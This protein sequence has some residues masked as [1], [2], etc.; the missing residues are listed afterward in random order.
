MLQSLLAEGLVVLH[1]AF[2]VF[3]AV[4]GLLVLRV[5]W[6]AWLHAPAALWTISV[7]A[8]G[9]ICPLT[10]LENALRRAAG[11]SGYE[12]G[13]VDHYVVPLVYPPGLT[14]EIQ[15]GLGL[16]LL[17]ANVAIYAVI[18]RRARTRRR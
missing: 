11:G 9:W 3:A 12:G 4:G 17:G 10:P 8:F 5:R 7:A 2:I 14:R 15:I 13:F 18:W 6:I 1:L 16:A